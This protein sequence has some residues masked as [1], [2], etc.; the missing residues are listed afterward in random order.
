MAATFLSP[1]R[2]APGA[3]IV[4]ITPQYNV[5]KIR[6]SAKAVCKYSLSYLSFHNFNIW[7]VICALQFYCIICKLTDHLKCE[8]DFQ[9][10]C[11]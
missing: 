3:T 6:F 10:N 1:A 5:T 9:Q 4:D 11:E 8:I 7:T 2:N